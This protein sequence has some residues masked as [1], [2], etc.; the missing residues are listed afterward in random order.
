MIL[1]GFSVFQGQ[2]EVL[3]VTL[4]LLLSALCFG[5]ILPLD[6]LADQSWTDEHCDTAIR[7]IMS[8]M[9]ILIGFGWEQCF[10]ASVDQIAME[11]N[12]VDIAFINPHTAKAGLTLFCCL[13]ISDFDVVT[14][15]YR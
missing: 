13:R 15:G 12:K 10:D 5:G 9:G 2:A 8:A 7:S 3:A 4:A 14:S 11:T 1:A 6:W